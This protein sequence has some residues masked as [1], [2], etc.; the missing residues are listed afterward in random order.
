MGTVRKG[1]EQ[2]RQGSKGRDTGRRDSTE[3]AAR[4]TKQRGKKAKRKRRRVAVG[5]WAHRCSRKRGWD[6]GEV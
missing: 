4:G 6:G 3:L 5:T 2:D 1:K